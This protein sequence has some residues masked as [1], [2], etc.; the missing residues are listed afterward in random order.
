MQ[1]EGKTKIKRNKTR[2]QDA[3]NVIMLKEIESSEALDLKF[4]FQKNVKN[5]MK[6][7]RDPNYLNRCFA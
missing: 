7:D 4:K 2:I 1:S 6:A 3:K 5:E